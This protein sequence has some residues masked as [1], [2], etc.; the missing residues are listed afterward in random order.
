MDNPYIC[1]KCGKEFDSLSAFH[2]HNKKEH[3]GK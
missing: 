1:P 2:V 3:G